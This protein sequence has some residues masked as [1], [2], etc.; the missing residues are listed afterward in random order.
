MFDANFKNGGGKTS[1][2]RAGPAFELDIPIG[3]RGTLSFSASAEF[4]RYR[5]NNATAFGVGGPKPIRSTYEYE[6]NLSYSHELDDKWSFFVAAGVNA[7]GE[8]GA[9]FGESLTYGGGGGVTYAF[10]KDFKLGLGAIVRTRLEENSYIV[11]LPLITWKFAPQW[12]FTTRYRNARLNFQAAD[13]WLIF[14]SAEFN[15]REYRLDKDAPTSQG[16]FRD[17]AIPLSLGVTFS[18][19]KTFEITAGAGVNLYRRMTLDDK[20]GNRVAQVK[21]EPSLL[22]FVNAAIKF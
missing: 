11:P 14:A 3:E 16:V 18:P 9:D 12:E 17:R 22:V 19:N 21:T 7:A 10:S 20:S 6:L 8:F 4:S 2:F 5:F 1:V 15:Q 13:Q